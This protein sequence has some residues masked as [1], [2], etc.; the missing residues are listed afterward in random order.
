MKLLTQTNS[1]TLSFCLLLLRCMVG[2]ILFAGGAGKALG[3]FGG[4]GMEMTAKY[5][6][7][8]GISE[9]WAYISAYSEFIG[10]FLI[11]IGLLTRPAAF[12][13]MINMIGATVLTM[14]K[15]F[16]MGMAAYPF[17]LMV[18]ALIIVLAGPMQ[19][20]LD[21]LVSGRGQIIRDLR[22]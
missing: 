6:G 2:V 7:M 19:F 18:S 12:A 9:P 3:W 22:R 5:Y 15:G 14:P 4:F 20:S 1:K 11:I 21:W 16:L 17:S 8:S 10:G 13:I